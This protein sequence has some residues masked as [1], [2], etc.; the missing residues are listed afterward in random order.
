MNG[1]DI[2]E[3]LRSLPPKAWAGIGVCAVLAL[4]LVWQWWPT[5]VKVDA[6]TQQAIDASKKDP[7]ANPPVADVA[8]N[9]EGPRRK[10]TKTK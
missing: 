10:A 1:D 3:K 4:V 6:Q 7:A 2:Q 9:P 5:S 8:A